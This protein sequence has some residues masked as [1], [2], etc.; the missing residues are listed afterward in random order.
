MLHLSNQLEQQQ[1]QPQQQKKE[2]TE[3]ISFTYL[4]TGQHF[5]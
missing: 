3:Q 5:K 1:Q 2:A 4:A